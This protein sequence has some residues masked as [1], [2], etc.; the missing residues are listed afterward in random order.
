[1]IIWLTLQNRAN[2]LAAEA[3]YHGKEE[4]LSVV[5]L[6]IGHEIYARVSVLA[7]AGRPPIQLQMR[8]NVSMKLGIGI[9][10]CGDMRL[11]FLLLQSVVHLQ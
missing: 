4:L 9:C 11:R 1:M 3:G 8:G 5:C 2:K 6:D 7:H 10:L